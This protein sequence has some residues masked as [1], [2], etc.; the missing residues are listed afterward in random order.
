MESILEGTGGIKMVPAVLMSL[1]WLNVYSVS[2][3]RM[4]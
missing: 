1:F 3:R 2:L 4:L